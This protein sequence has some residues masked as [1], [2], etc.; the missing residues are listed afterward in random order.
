ML[1]LFGRARLAVGTSRSDG[2]PLSC[3]EAL[4][5]GALPIQSNTSCL[6]EWIRDGETGLLVPP[7][8]AHV[9]A[10]AITRAVCDDALVDT[11]SRLNEETARRHFDRSVTRRQ[12]INMYER[13]AA[14]R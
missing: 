1:R 5:M 13:A 11:A 2:L 9:V 3:A 6:G 14:R 12:A 4:A 10:A 8:D 7:D